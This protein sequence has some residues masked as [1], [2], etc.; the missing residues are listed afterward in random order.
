LLGSGPYQVGISVSDFGSGVDEANSTLFGHVATDTV[1]P[2]SA[3][4]TAVDFA[5][6]SATQEC[7]YSVIYDFGGFYPPVYPEPAL[8]AVKAGSAVPLKFSLGGD[9]GLD[10]VAPGYPASQPL[11]CATFDPG[12]ELEPVQPA[13]GSGLSYD[14][15]SDQYTYVWKTEKGWAGTCRV[16]AL[17]FADGTQHLAYF[18][19]K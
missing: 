8:N 10:V 9:Q 15:A 2:K 14:V 7:T 3:T 18:Q 1:G 12:G 17:Q 13:G 19:F 6:N 4:F 5:G 16:L 11:D